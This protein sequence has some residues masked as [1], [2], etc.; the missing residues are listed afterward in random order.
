ME[1]FFGGS[2][3]VGCNC[4]SCYIEFQWLPAMREL[5]FGSASRVVD[6]S[7]LQRAVQIFA[8][9]CMLIVLVDKGAQTRCRSD[10]YN[11]SQADSFPRDSGVIVMTQFSFIGACRTV[12]IN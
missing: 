9:G 6:A 5:A 10:W 2:D 1:W 4:L 11:N 12:S 7:G 3:C 8:Y